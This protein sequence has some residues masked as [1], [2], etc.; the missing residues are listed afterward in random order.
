MAITSANVL[1][2]PL[3]TTL[4]HAAN[5]L[6]AAVFLVPAGALWAV[7]VAAVTRHVFAATPQPAEPPSTKPFTAAAPPAGQ[8]MSARAQLSAAS[9]PAAPVGGGMRDFLLANDATFQAA[10]GM[11]P[12]LATAL[13]VS[14]AIVL[15]AVVPVVDAAAAGAKDGPLKDVLKSFQLR[16]AVALGLAAPT[17]LFPILR[18]GLRIAMWLVGG[19]PWL[20]Y[21]FAGDRRVTH[22]VVNAEGEIVDES[23]SVSCCIA[24][25]MMCCPCCDICQPQPEPTVQPPM[26]KKD[27]SPSPT[28]SQTFAVPSAGSRSASPSVAPPTVPPSRATSLEAAAVAVDHAAKHVSV[29]KAPVPEPTEAAP[30]IE[31]GDAVIPTSDAK[32]PV[33]AKREKKEKKD[34]KEKDDKGS[35]KSKKSRSRS[36]EAAAALPRSSDLPPKPKRSSSKLSRQSSRRSSVDTEGDELRF[37]GSCSVRSSLDNGT[38]VDD[39]AAKALAKAER[40]AKRRAKKE[41]AQLDKEASSAFE[42]AVVV[43]A[44]DVGDDG[45]N[46]VEAPDRTCLAVAVEGEQSMAAPSHASPTLEL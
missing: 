26:E 18:F 17:V 21:R 45:P 16:V 34:K 12:G 15:G 30:Q 3:L 35:D 38:E 28:R 29:D 43:D 36:T 8:P 32:P 23:C 10:M 9:I 33:P 46:V 1:H 20:L 19:I 39:G 2:A 11:W 14:V 41:A 13:L 7:L 42:T 4:L 25:D 44:S 24:V 31:A 6:S 22:R 37:G 40:R 27:S 5:M